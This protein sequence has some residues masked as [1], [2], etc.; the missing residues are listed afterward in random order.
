[1]SAP[2]RFLE[3]ETHGFQIAPMLD[4]M[5]VILVFFMTTAG[6]RKVETQL[7]MN[8]P[9][10]RSIIPPTDTPMEEVIVVDEAGSISHNDEPVTGDELRKTFR[11]L[12][13][14]S[15][16]ES[17]AQSPTP[18]IVTISAAPDAKWENIA[19]VMNAMQ[20]AK[21]TNVSFAVSEEY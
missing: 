20:A 11:S 7:G 9:A 17:G 8:L 15:I 19:T 18:I 13:A 10:E 12:N 3:K 5:F 16:Q 4:I 1:M 14:Q 2:S 21:I 6:D